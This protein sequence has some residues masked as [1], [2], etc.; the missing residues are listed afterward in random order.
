MVLEVMRIGD[1]VIDVMSRGVV[2][3]VILLLMLFVYDDVSSQWK[4]WFMWWGVMSLL[5]EG[6]REDY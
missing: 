3:S 6:I 4:L 2:V 5:R 1:D